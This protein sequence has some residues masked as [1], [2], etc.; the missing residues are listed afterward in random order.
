[1]KT[2]S[3]PPAVFSKFR[4]ISRRARLACCSLMLGLLG[5]S[6]L[7]A[8][9][10]DLTAGD[11]IVHG[12]VWFNLGP[13]G[14]QAWVYRG[15]G[16][17][18]WSTTGGSR[19]ILVKSVEVG[20]PADGVL[21][22]GDVILGVDGTG[23]EPVGFSSDARIA[24]GHAIGEAE[25]QDPAL[26][27][28][29]VWRAGVTSTLTMTLR[30][31]GAYSAT[32][33]YNCPKSAKILEDG[34]NY[35]MS[36]E[37]VGYV[38]SSA[39]ALM[40]GNDPTNPAN[41][42][43]Q[44]KART[45]AL[46]Q[47][48]DPG[49]ISSI[50]AGNVEPSAKIAWDRGMRLI[51]LSEY[52]L[53]TGDSQVLPSI[54]ACALSIAHGQGANGAV[55]HRF[56]I[57]IRPGVY[58]EPFESGY[59]M[60]ASTL[61]ATLGLILAR[62]CGVTLPELDPAIERATRTLAGNA[63]LGGFNYYVEG[64]PL[65]YN[66]ENGKSAL[67]AIVF[68]MQD[69]RTEEARFF[70][71]LATGGTHK[72]EEGHIVSYF[73]YLWG[74]LGAN[75]G[76]QD[77]IAGNLGQIRWMMDLCR[78]WDGG[79]EYERYNNTN[80]QS[81]PALGTSGADEFWMSTAA[82]LT[83]AAPLGQIEITGR[84]FGAKPELVLNGAEVAEAVF[85]DY[86]DASVA[87]GRTTAELMQDVESEIP[88]LVVN[89]VIELG[90]RTAETSA[91]VP[92]L[93]ARAQDVQGR[94][95]SGAC[96]ALGA[97]GDEAALI[98]LI[99]L[100]SDEDEDIRYFAAEALT[101]FPQVLLRGQVISL[102]EILAANARPAFPMDRDDAQQLATLSLSE[103]LLGASGNTGAIA[104]DIN[105]ID[106][107]VLYPAIRA[108]ALHPHGLARQRVAKIYPLLNP[109][110]VVAL[111]DVLIDGVTN[112]PLSTMVTEP[113]DAGIG[114]LA[115][116]GWAEGVPLAKEI[117]LM[118]QR[119]SNFH[120]HLVA[121]EEYGASATT[122]TPDP[123]IAEFMEDVL[124][125]RY[126]G[127]AGADYEA[128]ITA[129]RDL[130]LAA[131]NPPVLAPLKTINSVTANSSVLTLPAKQTRL[132]TSVTDLSHG[133]TAYSWRKVH[134]PGAVTF[135]TN[136]S[137]ASASPTVIFGNAP[138]RYLFE[139]TAWD[140]RNLT[141]VTGTV[142]VELR[143]SNGSLPANAPP[144]ANAQSISVAQA[145]SSPI[146][147]TA[148]D[149]ESYP[150]VYEIIS[151]PTNG[152]L[153]GTAPYL[154]YT[155]GFQFTGAD[156][157]A[158]RVMDSDGQWSD[159]A[160]VSIT[161]A[162]R[163]GPVGLAVYEPV[164]YPA[165]NL[166]G[167][168]GSSEIGFTGVWEASTQPLPP[169]SVSANS[170]AYGGVATAGG[171][172]LSG[173]TDH[174]GSRPL[175]SSALA[176]SALLG[177]GATLWFAFQFGYS[178]SSITRN[179]FLS[180]ALAN[181]KFDSAS[182]AIQSEG[183]Q[184]GQGIGVRI[185]ENFVHAAA[186]GG[187]SEVG[188]GDIW[189]SGLT[190]HGLDSGLNR[191]FV[192]KITWGEEQDVVEVYLPDTD[193]V[194]GRPVS[195]VRTVVDQST[196]DT[197]TFRGS[198][199]LDEIRMG[200]TLASVLVGT[201]PMPL[202]TTPPSPDPM[203]FF[204]AP[205][206]ETPTSVT[207][208]AATAYDPYQV[209]YYF[210]CTAGAGNDSGWQSGA[211]YTDTGLTPGAAYSYTVKARDL[212]AA[213]NE[214]AQ[215]P[216]MSVNTPATSTV[217]DLTDL[218]QAEA[219]ALITGAGLVVGTVTSSPSSTTAAGAVES[220][221]LAAG[222]DIA[223]GS[224]ID[225]VIS[226]TI[227]MATVPSL[228]GQTESAAVS[229]LASLGLTAGTVFTDYSETIPAGAIMNQNPVSGA[230]VNVPSAVNLVVSA[231]SISSVLP[232]SELFS[233]D[234]ESPSAPM[235]YAQGTLPDNGNWVGAIAGFGGNRHGIIDKAGGGFS[236]PDPNHQGYAFR[237]ANSGL[238]TAEGVI[239]AVAQDVIYTV[240]F[241]VVR[242]DGFNAG[243]PYS[244]EL[245]A[246]V[247]EDDRSNATSTRTGSNLATTSGNAP[248]DGSFATVTL[249]FIVQPGDLRIGKD[250]ALRFLGGNS[251]RAIIDNVSVSVEGLR[252][253]DTARPWSIGT[254][255]LD[256]ST[257][258]AVESDL[259]MT[260]S[261]TVV[262]GSGLITLR[263]L[264]DGTHR[265]ILVSD[266]T[267]VSVDG[268]TLTINPSTD[269]LEN[270]EYA[271]LMNFDVV[272]DL[273]GNSFAGVT[274]ATVWNFT[275]PNTARPWS[276]GTTP[277]DN[278]TSV[279]V[280]S[281]LTM[282][283]S[284][285]VVRGSGLI[286]LRNLTDGTQRTILVSD[287]TQVSVDG[288][289]LTIN[290]STD[291]LE[292]KDYAVLMD[293][294]VVQD[295]AGNSFAGVTDATVWN[296]T[297]E[298]PQ[299][300]TP[301]TVGLTQAAAEAAITAAQ[302]AIG[303]VST[304]YSDTVSAGNV[305]S[306]NPSGGTSL[307]SGSPVDLVVSLGPIPD[308]TS[309]ALITLD[310]A[311]GSAGVAVDM[312]LTVTFDEDIAL[313]TGN[314]TLKNLTDA[315]DTLISVADA[316][317]VSISGAVLTIDPATD[318][319]AGKQYAVEIDATAIGDLAGNAFAG[320]LGETAWSFTVASAS[321]GIAFSED[322]ET[323]D[324][325]GYAQGTTPTGWVPHSSGF[326]SNRHGII[327]KA[328][329]AFFAADPNHQAY[330]FRYTA[331]PGI[332]TAEGVIG[333]LQAGATYTL[334]FDVQQ[335]LGDL[336][337]GG[338]GGNWYDVSLMAFDNGAERIGGPGGAGQNVLVAQRAGVPADGAF[339][340]V[341]LTFTADPV[342]HAA[343]IGKDVGILFSDVYLGGGSASSGV[344]DNIVLIHDGGAPDSTPPTL[345]SADIVD[346]A[347]GGPVIV[348]NPVTYTLT[349]SEDID[350]A[351]V[352]ASD[353]SNAGSSS[354]T[355]GTITE[356]SPGVFTV[357][358]TPTNSGTLQLQ[359]S[360]GASLNDAAGNTLDTT[361][362][363]ADDTIITVNMANVAPTWASNPINEANAT[364]DSAYI[365]TLA[366]DSS[367]A[368][369][370]PLTFTKVSGP[371]W[372]TVDTDGT[373]SGTPI[374][375][376]VGTNVF[377]VSVTDG[378]AAPVQATLNIAVINT[379]D[380]PVFA[381]SPIN[382]SDSAEDFA[383]AS[384]IAGSATD[385][386]GDALTYAKVSGPAWLSVAA[387]GD[388]TGTPTNADVGANAFTISVS[389]GIAAAVNAILNVTVINTNDAPVFAADPINGSDATEDTLYAATIA[390]S[391]SDDD[392]D[393][394]TYAKVSGPAWLSV[395][396]DGTLSGTP[397]N[398]E[399]GVNAF[400]VSV[401]D[402]IAPAVQ[403]ALNITVT[404]TNDAPVFAADPINGSDATED[405]LYAS[406]I[407]GS[408]SDDDS[409]PLTYTKVSGSAWLVV[410]PD[411]TLSGTPTN[412]DVG[413]NSFT[414]SVSDSIAPAVEATLNVTVDATTT[415][416]PDVVAQLQATAESN[417][418][419]ASLTVGTV[420]TE[421]S[422]TVPAGDVISQGLT[423]G[424]SV[425]VDSGVDLVVSLGIVPSPKLV[426]T[427]VAGVSST[428]WTSVDLGQAYNSPVI[429]A[430]PIY[431][432]NTTT[433][434]VTR[435][436]NVT[437]SG[438]DLKIDR[439]DGLTGPVSIDVSVVVVDEG[440][441]TQA[442]DG[443]TM[444]AVKFT[445][446]V[447]AEND[448]WV[449]ESRSFQNSYTT[450]VV[451]GQ[452]MSTN[453]ANWSVFWSMGDSQGNPVDASNL[454]V[455][456]H[457]GE[458]PNTTRADETIGYI[459]IESGVGTIDGVAYEAALG[460]DIV[461][462]LS[463]S[464]TPYTYTLSG[465]LNS[466]SAAA[467]SLAGMNGGDGGW[468]V[469][470]GSPAISGSSIGLYVSEDTLGDSEVGHIAEQVGYIV[471]GDDGGAPDSTPPTLA[472]ADIVDDAAG[473][474]VIV[475]NPV[476]YTLTFSEDIDDASVDA[477][478]FGNAG[479]AAL[480]IGAITETSAGVLTV[481][482][483]PTSTGTLQLQVN[484][485]AVITDVAG[486]ALDTAAAIIDDTVI[487]VDPPMITV[488]DVVGLAQATAET[489]I[490]AAN[491]VVGT[492]TTAADNTVPAGDVIS[493]NPTGGASIAEGSSVD[494]VVS[495]GPV[496]ISVST[497]AELNAAIAAAQP[498][499]TIVMSNGAWVD[500]VIDFDADGLPGQPITLRAELAG[501]V[502]LEGQS[503]L[504]IAGD[505]LVVQ[506]LHF[507]NGTIPAGGN[508]I[509]FRGS[510]SDLANNSRLTECAITDYNPVDPATNY[511]WVSIYGVGNR[512]DHCHFSG[513]N[514]IGVTLTVWPQAGGP[515]NNSRI[516]SNYF[517]DRALG[518]GNG[519]ETIRIGTSGVS[520]EV[521]NALVEGNYFYR[522]NGEIEI[523]SNK[524]VGNI[525]RRNTFVENN[526]QL[527]LRHGGACTVEGNYFFGNNVS[528]SSGVRVIGPDHVVINNYF[529][530]LNAGSRGAISLMN[531]IPDSPLNGYLRTERA[532]VAFNTFVNCE[533]SLTIGV[534]STGATLPPKDCVIAN[535]VVHSANAPLVNVLT[536]PENLLYEGN[537]MYGS[538]LG[539]AS[540]SGIIESDPLLELAADGLMRPAA[541]SPVLNAAAGS[542]PQIT[543]DMEGDARLPGSQDIGADEVT[544][545]PSSLPPIGREDVGPL[546]ILATVPDVIDQ[547]QAT[548]EANVTAA[549]F[550][551]GTVATDYS[552]IVS[553]GNVISQNPSG[554]TSL[555]KGSPV[556]LVVS[557]GS[558]P[559]TT[560]PTLA[561]ADIVDDAVGAPVVIDNPVTYTLTFSEDIDDAS[562]DASDFG[563]AGTAALTIGAITETSTGVFT[564]EVT[565]T[566]IGNLQLQ[567]NAGATITDV[568]GN[569]L[570]TT[571]AIIDDTVIAVDPLMTTVPDVLG[572]TQSSAESSITSAS[573][574]V[575]A[576]TSEYSGTVPQ[577]D[578]IS[579]GLTAG[580][581]VPVDS[582]VDL[583]V[584]LGID[585][586][587]KLVR[588]T[589]NAVSNTSWTTVDL[590]QTY[591]SAV[592]IA[593]PI[594]PTA[595]LP[596]VVTRITNITS[597]GFDLK[598]DRADGLTDPV[599]IDVSIIAI[600]EGVYTQAVD[601]VTMEAVK[602]TSTVTA[603]KSSW[604][605]EAR[606]FQNSYTNPVVVG[607]VMSAND[608]NWSVFWSMGS[609][610]KNPVDASN[611]NVG[612]H[613]AE[614]LNS[615]RA[616][617]TIGYIVIESGSGTINGIAYEAAL[618]GDSVQGF[619]NS[620]APYTY[621]LSGGLTS[622]STAAASVSGMDGNDGSW[623]VLSGSPALTTTSIGL[624]ACEDQ[625]GD[626]EQSHTT[627]QVGYI[628]FE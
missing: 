166:N 434:V 129:I 378:I 487:A 615:T 468:A 305:I 255:P 357:Q 476:T 605:A 493:Q 250:L 380:A 211:S 604:V 489:N 295:L 185:R 218:T 22:V 123:Q 624:H 115:R 625:I 342:Q 88:N 492:V 188:G 247:P 494:L 168:S 14:V 124:A 95:R 237:Y 94:G 451:V 278:S 573:L 103:V 578:V 274:D 152:T 271:V 495:S 612:K 283:L 7:A 553:A 379:N 354:V 517:G 498:G 463:D 183:E 312:S 101:K 55:G 557:L 448:S 291:L 24:F 215:S 67:G 76:G 474:P 510:S 572:L 526:G 258:V 39:L 361:T 149:P 486:N 587:P 268:T 49:V 122:V 601:G 395:A 570:D 568:A 128:R 396:A 345:A 212:S 175:S 248:A 172:I 177:D 402:S 266:T 335:D 452:V 239:G 409:D 37:N 401:D 285:T 201:V 521:S 63:G 621:S 502:T 61:P 447:T 364:E 490:V 244:A 236:A 365:A 11:P 138:G 575:G 610:F 118:Q 187:S 491:L 227:Q 561:S 194:L 78:H 241:D 296:F 156:S 17:I 41:A 86:Y 205:A 35:I 405:A 459:V 382:G 560:P 8:Q 198:E 455:G 626:S 273:A 522:C 68:A 567:V 481:E 33:P 516:D 506:G 424:S 97:I 518:T 308:S 340:T 299:T 531:G 104:L 606:S 281:D 91:L 383:Y 542:Y 460:S 62:K 107:T 231:G 289:T 297:T 369:S 257:S 562:V 507:K 412:S 197:L 20:S 336:D 577:G 431:P 311:P 44:D 414:V 186:F 417:I 503:K 565:P 597:S 121:F 537:I 377:T 318:L 554:G 527:T 389:D 180:F 200:G 229:S 136:H 264:T 540:S 85:S 304:A 4:I 427:T 392:G 528:G 146:I 191:L 105:N 548:A 563:N 127:S 65:T 403:A 628:V 623:A 500:T 25:A 28:M 160:T 18:P 347:T 453:D 275:T 391:A 79:F 466:A 59:T 3:R 282:T 220:Q 538:T 27:K 333:V 512:V 306:Q 329:G 609:Q 260:L 319:L 92:T 505:N 591:N 5:L 125:G 272:R 549:L 293:F 454:N 51:V 410:A 178:D 290:P 546:W 206:W 195:I 96:R 602:F 106:R 286:T 325:T 475:N 525:Y 470:A 135:S 532:L 155:S 501:M 482:A 277:L 322:F 193:M 249:Q 363:I 179:S 301:D 48:L 148:T 288:T 469:L 436:T 126:G 420:T 547:D 56:N 74:P 134:G 54:E 599:S 232:L 499:D 217:P 404:N 350:D 483:T 219:E 352:D 337:S 603:G 444:E 98:P 620:T 144:S 497:L 473:G 488:P 514:H 173:R 99:G 89:A 184:P 339:H 509:E 613:V 627:T 213:L 189:G 102:L 471:F 596:P 66:E 199:S 545:V 279:A 441:Y 40:A 558:V 12:N 82:L 117:I 15:G 351:S 458:D 385:D 346:D 393:P 330:A 480:T 23:A 433:S 484:A 479:T 423:A 303:S 321:S 334:S 406:T 182:V 75:V 71:K 90:T 221:S 418:L 523:I 162:T 592:I 397:A 240:S 262:R 224:T 42:A 6:P 192:G 543:T 614:D 534:T 386:D 416:V 430:T 429:V 348:N 598:I 259:T 131:D 130:L 307:P 142:A 294:D 464:S 209:E 9:A 265:A 478:D 375:T 450:P 16:T 316:T 93:L 400:I 360:A 256:D 508:V 584:S 143:D 315:S 442:V 594:Y 141:D 287:T 367:D 223:V 314:I 2:L 230:Q 204:N 238:T 426:R 167:K 154:T 544:A 83:Y 267:Q 541:N 530:D 181:S 109:D 366:D 19:Q 32:A 582:G 370:D 116:A 222:G 47:I 485:V 590:G 437:S 326:A 145:I 381:S 50:N 569:A 202:D 251:G 52:Y 170:L 80:Q 228:I 225:L 169:I 87:A 520:E 566:S 388:L 324:V 421:Y 374:N 113:G 425:P 317:Q 428:S 310:P 616:D 323:P 147:L 446:T 611:L 559:D 422:V 132:S 394:L 64:V 309:P 456:K 511:K 440:V 300:T 30:T 449:A 302:L 408:A 589:V 163:V 472:S 1:M 157:L 457:V 77:A 151:E 574:I 515:A 10:P 344:I 269:L 353:F 119:F 254:S 513:M 586:S 555:S 26:L 419:A 617:E 69:D 58:N 552:D 210:T 111:S 579:Q 245:V 341:T 21:E 415:L 355:F 243:T 190:G 328:S 270:K 536:A 81:T 196:F 174:S 407:A 13:T 45:Y 133:E 253:A 349:F 327:D 356:T 583:V 359:V 53:H 504:Q 576:V 73:N 622:A 519:F 618:G 387:N 216:A 100:L 246:M 284:E 358:A 477:S 140:A 588:T 462:G 435:I 580:S 252:F 60:N 338:G 226:S 72:R 467:V 413:L 36:N 607:Q 43:R 165:G 171:A 362:A 139:V 84:T 153:S 158:F 320:I 114:A 368:N 112:F 203:G 332:T 564:I 619:G 120:T 390:G 176:D 445:S 292:S 208:L 108:L 280:E 46:A 57:S 29:S 550:T 38:G 372:L 608:P 529:A 159:P 376:N 276:I 235:G 384:T 298:E 600:D 343:L 137:S 164:N 593:T 373:L 234:F 581:S 31:M 371:A 207:M 585:L 496:I 443:V 313:G 261:E 524:S 556:D 411:G 70:S 571:A 398:A 331:S 535:N 439:T 551:V 263:N 242:D 399:V 161:V 461:S 533:N 595:S 539:V 34:L 438:F 465:G 432:D 233:E 150:L 110:D 214:T